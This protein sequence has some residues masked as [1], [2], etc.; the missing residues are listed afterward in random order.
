MSVSWALHHYFNRFSEYSFVVFVGEMFTPR[1][2]SIGLN[3]SGS[4]R[5]L[6]LSSKDN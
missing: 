6:A 3:K 1:Q 4:F 2:L 5:L